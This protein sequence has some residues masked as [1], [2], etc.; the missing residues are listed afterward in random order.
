MFNL[1][2]LILIVLFQVSI[3]II[4]YRI[5]YKTILQPNIFIQIYYLAQIILALII[6][7][8]YK[9]ESYGILWISCA[10]FLF[11]LGGILSSGLIK[12][13]AFQHVGKNFSFNTKLAKYILIISTIVGILFP[14]EFLWERQIS[15]KALLNF[16]NLLEIN[17]RIAVERYTLGVSHS[18]IGSI[19]LIFV[20]FSPLIGG[21][22]YN[23]FPDVKMKYLCLFSILPA[24]LTLIV[25]NTKAVFL[26]AV[27]LFLSGYFAG[28]VK[29]G[30]HLPKLSVKKLISI[31]VLVF[32]FLG[33]LYVSMIFRL[34]KFDSSVIYIVNKKFLVYALGHVPAFDIWFSDNAFSGDHYFGVRTFCG[35]FDFL[36]IFERVQGI[37][38]DRAY[39]LEFSSNVYTV[40]RPLVEDFGPYLGLFIM[41]LFGFFM[42]IVFNL[43]RYSKNPRRGVVLLSAFYFYVLYFVTSVW[44][45]MSFTV[46]FVLF[47]VYLN[48]V[49]RK[50][51]YKKMEVLHE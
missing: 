25:T 42:N 13:I 41:M 31:L 15:I 39:W 10:L 21:F 36:G 9:F 35:I 24:L 22:N 44:S 26:G 32:I 34:G 20:Y 19:L 38:S 8:K 37:Y 12:K 47:V 5:Y 33:I 17:H 11:F 2:T 14:I 16:T 6:F 51:K 40:Y 29:L 3:V 23:F 49:I 1:P 7:N 45:Y 18:K 4:F 48:M 50:R 46:C 43:T 30:K 27:F 28:L